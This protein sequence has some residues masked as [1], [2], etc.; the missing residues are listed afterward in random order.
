M[1]S[2]GSRSLTATRFIIARR[3]MIRRCIRGPERWLFLL[4]ETRVKRKCGWSRVTKA[5][6]TLIAYSAQGTHHIQDGPASLPLPAG[7]LLSRS[8]MHSTFFKS[9][10][11]MVMLVATLAVRAS[12]HHSFAAEYDAKKPVTLKGTVTK[13]AW[14]NPHGWIYIDVKQPSGKVA[15]WAVEAGSPQVLARRGLKRRFLPT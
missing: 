6:R 3:L 4:F 8:T 9:S 13:V 1:S 10:V 11:I 7:K 15:N 5:R 12:A 14:V 2:S